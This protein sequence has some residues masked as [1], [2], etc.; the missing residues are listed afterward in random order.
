MFVLI[1]LL[2]FSLDVYASVHMNDIHVAACFV[3]AIGICFLV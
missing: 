2:E 3:R 1:I